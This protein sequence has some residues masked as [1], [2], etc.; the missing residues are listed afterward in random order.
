MKEP[1]GY[2]DSPRPRPCSLHK[3][4][5]TPHPTQL[6]LRVS[7]RVRARIRVGIGVRVRVWLAPTCRC[8]QPYQTQL[9]TKHSPLTEQVPGNVTDD[10]DGTTAG[11]IH[12]IATLRIL[13]R[14]FGKTTSALARFTIRCTQPHKLNSL[15]TERLWNIRTPPCQLQNPMF[16][17]QFPVN[18]TNPCKEN[19]NGT[20]P[21]SCGT[22]ILLQALWQNHVSFL[23]LLR[24]VMRDVAAL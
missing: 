14:H 11:H 12:S 5:H 15:F 16:T 10:V 22:E 8:T 4:L 2:S 6:P 18:R 3:S 7:I 23:S 9:S 13:K 21:C 24:G 17:E 1:C 19:N 20:I